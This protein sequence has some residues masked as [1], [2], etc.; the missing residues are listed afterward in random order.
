MMP[1]AKRFG[2][3][4]FWVQSGKRK[5]EAERQGYTV[6]IHLSQEEKHMLDCYM[7]EQN[8][9]AY[10]HALRYCM[11]KELRTWHRSGGRQTHGK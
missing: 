5:T 1:Y 11:N 3:N 4:P 6:T 7:A 10:S 2:I 9:Q 8:I